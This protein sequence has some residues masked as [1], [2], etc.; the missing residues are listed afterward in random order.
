MTFRYIND[1]KTPIGDVLKGAASD[2]VVLDT[3][4]HKRFAMIPLDDDLIDYLLER[5]PKF[6]RECRKID[7]EMKRREVLRHSKR[8]KKCLPKTSAT[9]GRTARIIFD[10]SENALAAVPPIPIVPMA[11]RGGRMHGAGLGCWR[12][13]FF[14]LAHHR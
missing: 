11:I 4:N 10:S 1:L 9:P 13:V 5:N 7:A 14:S 3:K 12:R 6:I 8:S 2:G